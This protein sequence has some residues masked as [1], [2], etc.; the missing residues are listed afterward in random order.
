MNE[1]NQ[2]KRKSNENLQKQ[3][4]SNPNLDHACKLNPKFCVSCG[5]GLQK[6]SRFCGNCGAS[7][8]EPSNFTRR[9][10]EVDSTANRIMIAQLR[11]DASDAQLYF[12]EII[13]VRVRLNPVNIQI[14]HFLGLINQITQN[15]KKQEIASIIQEALQSV[16]LTKAESMLEE[17]LDPITKIIPEIIN[18]CGAILLEAWPE[19]KQFVKHPWLDNPTQ[20]GKNIQQEL[21]QALQVHRQDLTL[22]QTHFQQL[23]EYHPRYHAI[24]TRIGIWDFVLGFA[25]GFFGGGLGSIGA[26]AWENWRG[27]SDVEFIQSFGNAVDQF[28][29]AALAFTQKTEQEVEAVLK[30]FLKKLYDLNLSV[31]SALEAFIETEDISRIYQKLHFSDSASKPD[32]DDKQFFEIVISNLRDQKISARSE[33]NIREVL[34]LV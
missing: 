5:D 24:M 26:Q 6:A 33:S 1:D 21:R 19:S 27:K 30:G 23:Q 4:P 2:E 20:E 18:A 13:R 16:D 17:A 22:I 15:S 28:S 34:G 12:P 14:H 32:E 10:Q 31:I 11:D 9:N 3:P 29:N 8:A 7:T 25:A